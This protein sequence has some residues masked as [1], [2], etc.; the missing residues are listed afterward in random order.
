MSSYFDSQVSP[1]SA[2]LFAIF[3]VSGDIFICCYIHGVS[4]LSKCC[5]MNISLLRVPKCCSPIYPNYYFTPK[6]I[7]NEESNF[8]WYKFDFKTILKN[9]R[10]MQSCNFSCRTFLLFLLK[11]WSFCCVFL[12][13]YC[14][15]IFWT[16]LLLEYLMI[17]TH[18]IWNLDENILYVLVALYAVIFIKKV[19]WWCLRREL[20]SMILLIRN[21]GDVL[22]LPLITIWRIYNLI[23]CIIFSICNTVLSDTASW[24]HFLL[25][26]LIRGIW[27]QIIYSSAAL[28]TAGYVTINEYVLQTNNKK[29]I[30]WFKLLCNYDSDKI[31]CSCAN[32]KWNK[33]LN[34]TYKVLKVIFLLI[35]ILLAIFSTTFNG[36][37]KFALCMMLM[38]WTLIVFKKGKYNSLFILWRDVLNKEFFIIN[39][40][41]DNVSTITSDMQSGIELN[42]MTTINDDVT[43]DEKYNS[44]NKNNHDDDTQ[45]ENI[46]N[47]PT[48]SF[49]E[50][51][52]RI[53]YDHEP[54]IN[55]QIVKKELDKYAQLSDVKLLQEDINNNETAKPTKQKIC[56]NF[57]YTDSCC[58]WTL[59]AVISIIFVCII[60]FIAIYEKQSN[61]NNTNEIDEHKEFYPIFEY[62]GSL[63]SIDLIFLTMMAY[64]NEEDVS[65]YTRIWF[66]NTNW[67]VIHG[68]NNPKYFHLEN[69]NNNYHIVSVAG[70]DDLPT[71]I[72]DI[73]LWSE[74]ATFQLFSMIIPLTSMLPTA[75]IREFVWYSSLP[76][77]FI[78]PS[79]RD[80]YY[81][82]IY[83]YIKNNIIN[84]NHETYIYILGHSLGGGIAE[85]VGAKLYEEFKNNSSHNI[86]SFGLSSPGT[87]YAS[88]KFG[89]SI[90]SL[91]ASST[92]IIPRRDVVGMVDDHGGVIQLIECTQKHIG[93]CH[94]GMTSFC[95]IVDAQLDGE[96]GAYMFK[97]EKYAKCLC[98]TKDDP[99]KTCSR[100]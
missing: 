98:Q 41:D 90:E 82:P 59:C 55:A 18:Y 89:F 44:E 21:I 99:M 10:D 24:Q 33:C 64:G 73:S 32:N 25:Y 42:T 35:Y 38:S 6:Q 30:D 83:E 31:I 94:K 56:S 92:S 91:D 87:L 2:I 20:E 50:F 1:L 8:E 70:T 93:T 36:L 11:L 54:N 74:I 72:Q 13:F 48:I 63:N 37:F 39:I 71:V 68:G 79:V 12:S 65:T 57:K 80:K 26:M 67:S 84:K 27:W 62:P 52:K 45:D 97:N 69:N 34:I 29:M 4:L 9:V 61:L 75:F 53:P 58:E 51:C 85:I 77:W 100:K 76:E 60:I 47:I 14:S 16:N 86:E 23:L 81:E 95:E 28:I 78:A 5:C 49:N 88:K 3:V 96:Y 7:M 40:I 19:I 66:N 46:I 17:S 43:Q 22:N 15:L